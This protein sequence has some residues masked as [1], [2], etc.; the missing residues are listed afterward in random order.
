MLYNV[1][2]TIKTNFPVRPRYVLY[3]MFSLTFKAIVILVTFLLFQ[4]NLCVVLACGKGRKNSICRDLFKTKKPL[5]KPLKTLN[6]DS[7][8]ASGPDCIP[9]VVLKNCES[10]LSCILVEL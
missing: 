6:F 4:S 8:K 2:F 1:I 3:L 5:A 7:S 9:V 10:E